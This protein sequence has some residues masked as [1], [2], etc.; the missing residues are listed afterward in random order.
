[1]SESI[2]RN[3]KVKISTEVDALYIKLA[4][5]ILPGESVKNESFTLRSR[6]SEVIFDLSADNQLLGIEIL[7]IEGLLK[8]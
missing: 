2:E 6:E 8:E 5:D 3:A 4:T 1:M 7:G